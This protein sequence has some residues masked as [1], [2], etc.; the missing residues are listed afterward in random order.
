MNDAGLPVAV[1]D[2]DEGVREL[3]CEALLRAGL[4]SRAYASAEDFLA[5]EAG[6]QSGCAV[7]DSL[8]PGISGTELISMLRAGGLALPVVFISGAA[9]ALT[10]HHAH[11]LGAQ[12]MF[13]KPFDVTALVHR[14]ASLRASVPPAWARQAPGA[15]P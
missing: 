8:L 14:V 6:E 1:I 2:D 5:D 7:I 13:E 12:A 11:E 4:P 10:F 3:L 9:G 15:G